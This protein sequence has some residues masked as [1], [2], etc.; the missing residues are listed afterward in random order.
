[1]VVT[2]VMGNSAAMFVTVLN[3]DRN[4]TFVSV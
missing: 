3:D 4:N 2:P 1:M